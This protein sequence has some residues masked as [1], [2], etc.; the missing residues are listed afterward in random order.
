MSQENIAVIQGIYAAFLRGDTEHILNQLAPKFSWYNAGGPN[1]PY[2]GQRNDRAGVAKFFSTLAE[3]ADVLGFEAKQY[4]SAGNN[5]AAFGTFS[6][7]AK[8]T[9]KSYSYEWAMWWTLENGKVVDYRSYTD[10]RVEDNAF[11]KSAAA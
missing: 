10:T 9:G 8:S 11:V 6:A 3:T 1:V 2:S 7:R 5:V 4:T